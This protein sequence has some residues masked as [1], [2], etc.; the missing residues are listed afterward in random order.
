MKC[1]VSIIV[2]IYN[3]EKYVERCIK[4]L[5]NQTYTNIEIILVNDGS[6]D[7]SKKIIEK[8][9]K[10]DTRIQIINK[11]NGG[12]SSAR[13][14]GLNMVTGDYILY[15]DGDDYLE[16]D[17]IEK[18]MNKISDDIDIIMFPYIKEYSTKQVKCK[19]FKEKEILFSNQE[20]HEYIL[21]YLIGPGVNKISYSPKYM[22]RL[23][24]AWGKLYKFSCI[25]NIKFVDTKEIGIEDGWYNIQV[26]SN[27]KG[28]ILYTEDI[29]YRYEKNNMTSLLHSYNENFIDKRW[30]FY[31]KVLIFLKENNR[32]D[33]TINLYNRIIVE[34]FSIVLNEADNQMVTG[35]IVKVL[36]QKTEYHCYKDYFEKISLR[37]LSFNWR[38]FFILCRYNLYKPIVLFLKLVEKVSIAKNKKLYNLF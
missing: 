21:P 13:N 8:Y 9:K 6:K 32:S 17:S 26:I 7:N 5:I 30:N 1:K 35:D 19:L 24:T 11:L 23:N 15:V 29:W 31:N 14:A 10:C 25:R 37:K 20:V 36:K 27:L 3:I 2:P 16:I 4:S 33:L 34:L 18:L 38:F 12:L 28:K 22:D